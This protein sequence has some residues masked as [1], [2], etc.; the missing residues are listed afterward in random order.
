[1]ALGHEDGCD[2]TGCAHQDCAS[3]ADA[4][5][6]AILA[7]QGGGQVALVLAL[8]IFESLQHNGIAGFYRCDG[9]AGIVFCVGPYSARTTNTFMACRECLGIP[10]F[11]K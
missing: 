4:S 6:N 2:A 3:Y 1:M 7:A 10:A 5:N 8:T 11:V 9:C